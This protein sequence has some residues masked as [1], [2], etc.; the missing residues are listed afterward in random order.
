MNHQEVNERL[1]S[2]RVKNINNIIA[3]YLNINTFKNKYDFLKTLVSENIDVMIICETKLDDSF[4]MSQFL[5]AGFAEPFRLHRDKK[6]WGH[7]VRDFIPCKKLMKHFFPH[8]IEGMFI[9]LNFGKSQWLLF[10][11]YHQNV[12][13]Y[14]RNV[15][16]ALDKYIKTYDKYLLAGDFN[17][18]VSEKKWKI[19]W[20]LLV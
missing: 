19:S 16:R 8:D 5:I 17:A 9:E 2:I 3:A 20:R 15:G 4:P 11:T 7:P 12:E 13:Y 18:E 6:W 10:S 1:N 14:L